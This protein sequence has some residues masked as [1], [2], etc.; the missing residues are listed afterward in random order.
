[1][2]VIPVLSITWLGPTPLYRA[3][4]SATIKMASDIIMRTT[5]IATSLRFSELQGY[6]LWRWPNHWLS[7][8]FAWKW[9][10]YAIIRFKVF[11]GFTNG[12]L[13]QLCWRKN[14][15]FRGGPELFYLFGCEVKSY[16]FYGYRRYA[17]AFFGLSRIFL[18]ICVNVKF[19]GELQRAR[20]NAW[21]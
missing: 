17:Y 20:W 19:T 21:L 7:G 18:D 11:Q 3:T 13:D 12:P 8:K 4:T 14:C 15:R 9:L 6:A 10:N 16:S 1:M 2:K 5:S